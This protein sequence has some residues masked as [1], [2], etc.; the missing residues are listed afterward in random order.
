MLLV[1]QNQGGRD[2]AR[3]DIKSL[4][5]LLIDV[6]IQFGVESHERFIK[7]IWYD[8]ERKRRVTASVGAS[9]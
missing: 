4:L 2:L 1:K 9:E 6:V 5:Y 7:E 8:P 3:G